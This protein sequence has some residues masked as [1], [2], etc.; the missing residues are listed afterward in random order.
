MSFGH[1]VQFGEQALR[2]FFARQ[3]AI[4]HTCSQKDNIFDLLAELDEV[5]T[6]SLR[7]RYLKKTNF[8]W[9]KT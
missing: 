3:S 1:F 4:M 6:C 2:Y 8:G 7:S 5:A 9:R